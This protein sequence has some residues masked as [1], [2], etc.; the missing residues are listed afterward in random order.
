MSA[1]AADWSLENHLGR[2]NG[3]RIAGADEVGRG[4]VCGCFVCAAALY[5]PTVQIPYPI[6]ESKSVNPEEREAL[7]NRLIHDY[8][9]KGLLHVAYA[10]ASVDE[11]ESSNMNELNLKLLAEALGKLPS[12]DQAILDGNSADESFPFPGMCIPKADLQ[13]I[14]VATASLFAKVRRDRQMQELD[15]HYP[16]YG[17]AA[18]MGYGVP[19]H[20]D[21]IRKHGA[22]PGVHRQKF[23]RKF[24]QRLFEERS[25]KTFNLAS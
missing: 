9:E 23:L 3:L 16:Q 13:S 2:T 6:R 17:F 12:F 24:N 5:E 10:E 19:E 15:K 4:C 21:A 7:V 1:K 14:T 8:L 11:V 18:H 25:Q 20:L 22:I